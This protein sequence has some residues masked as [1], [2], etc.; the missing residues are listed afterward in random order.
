MASVRSRL[1]MKATRSASL[2][3]SCDERRL[4][5]A[6][7]ALLGERLDDQRER[8]PAR[9]PHG[10]AHAEDGELRHR[11]AVVGQQLLRDALVARQH[12]AARVAAGVGHAQQLEVADHV[13]V[14]DR[15]VVEV[16]QQVEDHVR[17][18]L[19]RAAVRI[20]P[21]SLPTPRHCTSW[22][23]LAQRADDVELGLPFD[24]GD[25][26]ALHVVGRHQLLVHQG[27]QA[28]L[29]HRATR[30]RPLRTK[31]MSWLVSTIPKSSM[32]CSG[33]AREAQP[34]LA[35]ALDHVVQ[36][37]VDGVVVLAGQRG[38]LA[39]E[40]RCGRC[41]GSSRRSE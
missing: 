5:D 3:S 12:Q 33:G 17:L 26:D 14:V 38:H 21:R 23:E 15:H 31:R 4:R 30:C 40:L 36:D 11:D 8:E 34:Q 22:P 13:L 1:W 18:Q 37:Q 24:V 2:S 32:V 28:Q 6:R 29:L 27:Q 20:A 16:L 9:P 10:A 25:V 41:A 39:A 35:R 7:G 19:G